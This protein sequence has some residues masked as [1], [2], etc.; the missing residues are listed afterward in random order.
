MPDK[1]AT[2]QRIRTFGI[3][4]HI[5]AGKTTLSE[6]LLFYTGRE[7]QMGEV[8]EGTAKMDYLPEEQ[9]RGITITAAATT[10]QWRGHE[11]HLIDT[12]GHVDFTA[13][14]ERSLRVLDGAV[15]VFDA[16]NGVEAQ[17]ETVWRQAT[18]YHVP[19]CC[20]LNKMDRPGA[21]FD[22]SLESIRQRLGA[23]PVPITM[24]VGSGEALA[25]VVDLVTMELLTFDPADHG[26][27]VRRGPIPADLQ[28]EAELRRQELVDVVVEHS[29]S[30]G[31]RFLAGEALTVDALKAG[32]REATLAARVFPALCGSAFKNVGVQT[33][34]DAIVDYLPSPLDAG[35]IEGRDPQ[36]HDRVEQRHP[37]PEE[38]LCAL[39][40]KIVGDSH[41]D[42][43]FA[44]I[45][46]GTLAQGQG[47]WNPRLGKHE[48]A[49]RLLRMHANEREP[50]DH[51]VAGDIVALVGLKETATGDTLC[52]RKAPIVLEAMHFPEP[53]MS[54]RIEPKTNADRDRLIEALARLAREDPTFRTH[55]SPDTG[56]TLIEGMGEL[57]LEVLTHRLV[58]DLGVAANVGKPR[59]AY[60]QTIAGS[61][62]ATSTFEKQLAS[63]LHMATVSLL[64]E[65]APAS[66]GVAFANR[67]RTDAVPPACVAAVER[68]IRSAAGGTAGFAWPAIDVKATLLDGKTHEQVPPSEIAF[69]AAA[70]RAYE[71][72]FTAAGPVLLEP[73]MRIEVHTPNEFTGDILADLNRRRVMIE[74][75]EQVGDG[76][77]LVGRAPLSAMFGYSTTV[78]SL[79][80]GR[81]GYSME[82]CGYEPVPPDKAKA[83]SL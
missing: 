36:R 49:M 67:A 81:A 61:G 75:N 45:Y 79:S 31:E 41:G 12:P 66:G 60:R 3:V 65:S 30:A 52:D 73:A 24:P 32:L 40:F 71:E 27:T 50:V 16:V 55:V 5:D 11:L 7:H 34:L 14:V 21:D 58:R 35:A 69:E 64:L 1:P 25:G 72:A 76:R 63:K 37:D 51:A 68:G 56:E 59:V 23:L 38:P 8:H 26:R 53:V 46:S 19:R 2:L 22:R 9:E 83:L 33:V 48:R 80:Q 18:R 47:L 4:A 10:L 77:V 13:E 29:P 28:A 20:F 17:S 57:H 82:P 74:S 70:Y 6:R 43:T 15:V 39:A 44:R 54:M 78:R 42:L 62:E